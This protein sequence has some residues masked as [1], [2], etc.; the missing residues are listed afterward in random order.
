MAH[1]GGTRDAHDVRTLVGR[2]RSRRCCVF[3]SS[4][5]ARP[6]L[7]GL[8]GDI[9][10]SRSTRDPARASVAPREAIVRSNPA[11]TESVV[12]VE[13]YRPSEHIGAAPLGS[14]ARNSSRLMT[15]CP[16]PTTAFHVKHEKDRG[17]AGLCVG[18]SIALAPVR[19]EQRGGTCRGGRDPGLPSTRNPPLQGGIHMRGRR[20]GLPRASVLRSS[21]PQARASPAWAS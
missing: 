1:P 11:D 16:L 17:S 6:A 2:D 7:S 9:A 14:P 18:Q 5:S 21:D 15:P 12:A 20:D 10:R 3:V 8:V 4:V 19:S 13:R